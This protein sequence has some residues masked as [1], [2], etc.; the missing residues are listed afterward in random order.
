[1]FQKSPWLRRVLLL[2][3]LFWLICNA[4]VLH[5]YYSFSSAYA[6]YNQGIFDQLFW[7][8]LHG[9]WFESSLSSQLS[10]AVVHDQELPLVSYRR[11]GQ[12]FTPSLLLW[13][14]FY[15]LYPSPAGLS[16]LQTT[17]I[18]LS[19]LVLYALVR[20][21]HPPQIA[22]LFTASLYASAA[23]LGPTL[24][25]FRDFSQLL[26]FTFGLLWALE[27]QRWVLFWILA[28]LTLAIR[29]DAG[30]VLFSIG[31]YL[32]LSRRSPST[33]ILLSVLSLTYILVVTNIIMPLFSQDISQRFMIEQFGHFV[34][35]DN[36]ST[37]AV[38]AAILRQPGRLLIELI[39]PVDRT[40]QYLLAQ[41]LPLAFVPLLSPSAWILAAFPTLK[42]LIRQAPDALSL[43]LR[44]AL[45]LVPGL[46]YGAILWW[47]HHSEKFNRRSQ[48]FWIGCIL[49]SLCLTLLSNPNRALSFVIADSFQPWVYV[50]PSRQWQHAQAIRSL[51]SQIPA[52]A[53]VSSTIHIAGHL[54]NRRS[55]LV[56]PRLRLRDDTGKPIWMDYAIVD[57]WSF[58]RYQ[59]AFEDDRDRLQT[60]TQAVQRMLNAK[61]SQA[62][63]LIDFQDGVL[64]LQRG[65]ESDGRAIDWWEEYQ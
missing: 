28:C 39:T 29:E 8:S 51:L 5:R 47:Q 60:A 26:L 65:V 40:L 57:L 20:L 50:P 55:L 31:V 1:M 62:Y 6:N 43:N 17:L 44:Y 15:A 9:R 27:K 23:V 24:A 13:L 61:G 64:L 22:F 14:P 32:T 63:G 49:L 4:L 36:A 10:S 41:A 7:N 45:T 33:G 46:F 3:L 59:A 12:H 30:V 48:R 42:V 18:A 37:L 53:S 16:V 34:D 21:Y 11:L 2:T 54:S 19:G 52:D 58:Q 38:I 35:D 25:D 56:F